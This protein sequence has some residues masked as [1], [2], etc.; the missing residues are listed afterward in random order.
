VKNLLA[1]MRSQGLV[2][3]SVTYTTLI[4]IYGKSGRFNDAIECLDDMKAAG[5]K[6]SSTMY[7]ALINAYAQRVC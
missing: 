7:N 6:P 4:D 3:N 5:L 1:H 2:P